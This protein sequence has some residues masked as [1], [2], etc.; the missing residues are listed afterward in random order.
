MAAVFWDRYDVLLV[1]FHHGGDA[2][3]ALHRSGKFDMLTVRHSSK[4]S[5]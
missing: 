2:V 1:D 4:K 5:E 3:N